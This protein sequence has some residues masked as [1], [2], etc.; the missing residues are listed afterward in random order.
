VFLPVHRKSTIKVSILSFIYGKIKTN[1]TMK[2]N[3]FLA[4]LFPVLLFSCQK[5]GLV[6]DAP[7]CIDAKIEQFKQNACSGS[8]NVS[9]YDFQ[10]KKVYAFDMGTCMADGTTDILDENCNK[11][12]MLGGLTGN[13]KCNGVEFDKEAKNKKVVWQSK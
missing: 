13:T 7:K 6:K 5:K 10:G 8:G 12:C 2:K 3:R 11:V 9:S 1:S 4:L